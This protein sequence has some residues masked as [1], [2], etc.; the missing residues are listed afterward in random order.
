MTV[1]SMDLGIDTRS[2]GGGD[3][4]PRNPYPLEISLSTGTLVDGV[5]T[6]TG[7]ASWRAIES[8]DIFIVRVFDLT[9]QGTR[10]TSI[11]WG[12][13]I[14]TTLEYA[15]RRLFTGETFVRAGQPQPAPG[16]ASKTVKNFP[17][18]LLM[19][20]AGLRQFPVEAV[21]VQTQYLLTV[22]LG[23]SLTIGMDPPVPKVYSVD[24]EMVVGPA[25]T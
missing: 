12:A 2:T 11:A 7:L 21:T 14:A 23:V 9:L 1:Y 13:C 22:S 10:L 24:P 25:G 16:F 6:P 8:H 17:C 5:Y 15:P 20:G 3:G 19:D 4:V 18:W